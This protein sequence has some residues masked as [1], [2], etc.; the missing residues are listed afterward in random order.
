MSKT[1]KRG[2][3]NKL[4]GLDSIKEGA[5]LTGSLFSSLKPSKKEFIKEEFANALKRNGIVKSQENEHLIKVYRHQSIQGVISLLGSIMLCYF[6]IIRLVNADNIISALGG[7]S[8]LT[9]SLAMAVISAGYLF[10][11]FQVRYKR[12]GM[13][14]YWFKTPK[15][16][17]PK[18][19]SIEYLENIDEKQKRN[20]NNNLN[21]QEYILYI[22]KK[23]TSLGVDDE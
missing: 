10:R 9:I 20:K 13:L 14:K 15:E 19:I 8:Y 11:A 3:F 5:K 23:E 6:G 4:L 22:N 2:L 1:K 16:W 21:D 17:F 12:L 7:T 18:K